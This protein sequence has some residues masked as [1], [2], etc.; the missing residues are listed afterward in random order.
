MSIVATAVSPLV[1][2]PVLDR[3]SLAGDFDFDL[4]FTPD[5]APPESQVPSIF[6]AL[7]EQLGLKLEAE[8]TSMDT[9]IIDKASPPTPN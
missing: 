2:R 6:T 5:A 8:R 1:S 4:K 9:L 7:Q 3:T